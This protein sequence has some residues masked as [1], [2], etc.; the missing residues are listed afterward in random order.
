MIKLQ[1]PEKWNEV[2]LTIQNKKVQD[3]GPKGL[4]QRVL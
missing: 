4:Q 3:K 2:Q 1:I